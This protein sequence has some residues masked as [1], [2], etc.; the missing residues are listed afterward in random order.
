MASDPVSAAGH[1]RL[2]T[3]DL[4][5]YGM[6]AVLKS[7]YRFTG[8]CF[9]HLQRSGENTVELRMRPKRI[10]EDPDSA[11]RDFLNDL[12]E[13]RLRSMVAAET[14]SMRDLIMAHALSRTAL[15]RP[16]LETAEPTRDL[17]NDST[18]D[19]VRAPAP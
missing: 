19:R 15:I 13:Q 12:L 1:D 8:R 7:A 17:Q 4:S 6:D 9:V 5:V 2:A 16:D 18:S 11:V 10:E 14:T 3:I